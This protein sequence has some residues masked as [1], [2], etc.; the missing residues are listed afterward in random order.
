[1]IRAACPLCRQVDDE[2]SGLACTCTASHGSQQAGKSQRQYQER[3]TVKKLS[4]DQLSSFE[5]QE[6]SAHNGGQRKQRGHCGPVVMTDLL[7]E[8]RRRGRGTDSNR[9]QE[10]FAGPVCNQDG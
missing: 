9:P 5:K 6:Q 1:M 10:G 4:A 8:S 7:R 2:I 3:Q